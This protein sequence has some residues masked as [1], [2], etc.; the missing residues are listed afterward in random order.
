MSTI[1]NGLIFTTL[2][3]ATLFTG[4]ASAEFEVTAFGEGIAF[5]DL[6][7]GDVAAAK[8]AFGDTTLEAMDFL[9]ANNY[10]VAMIL[11]KDYNAAIA[12]CE[13]ALQKIDD[14]RFL[15]LSTRRKAVSKIDS[16]LVVAKEL[17]SE[18]IAA[19]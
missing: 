6:M 12:S 2:G 18:L 5:E 17:A 19:N 14:S 8:D 13:S 4:A 16:N 10:C 11:E 7:S 1:K 3:L 9:A 15:G